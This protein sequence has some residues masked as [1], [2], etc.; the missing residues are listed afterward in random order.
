[1]VERENAAGIEEIDIALR[2][3]SSIRETLIVHAKSRPRLQKL[4]KLN[5]FAAPHTI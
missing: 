2:K 3:N 4:T 5:L 1:L